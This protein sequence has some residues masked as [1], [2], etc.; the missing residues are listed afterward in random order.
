[1]C[2]AMWSVA[3]FATAGGFR[4]Q[5]ANAAIVPD[6]S[7][8]GAAG[9][10]APNQAGVQQWIGTNNIAT[11]STNR[12]NTR[13]FFQTAFPQAVSG[14][15]EFGLGWDNVLVGAYVGGSINT[16]TG[17]FEGGVSLLSG[18]SPYFCGGGGYCW[19]DNCVFPGSNWPNC[20]LSV[21]VYVDAA[22]MDTLT[23]VVEGD[24][25]TDG[26]LVGKPSLLQSSF[27]PSSVPSAVPTY[28]KPSVDPSTVPTSL[29]PSVDP[30]EDPT[31]SGPTEV[32]SQAP[33]A[34]AP[35]WSDC[36]LLFLFVPSS[37]VTAMEPVV[38]C[39]VAA[40][41]VLLMAASVLFCKPRPRPLPAKQVDAAAV[42]V[43]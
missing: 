4:G 18:T 36:V 26:I 7:F 11:V 10:W 16:D 25:T 15:L 28:A 42:Y 20:V 32:P 22:K 27:R 43:L 17:L 14:E 6:S 38:Q 41:A 1:M 13:Y 31:T 30:S 39:L 9:H 19:F 3:W 40:A 33:T 21:K 34:A 37:V 29:K 35:S 8:G 5:V 2:D 23:L 24:G 12:E